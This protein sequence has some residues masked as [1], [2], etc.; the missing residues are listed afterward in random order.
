MIRPIV[1]TGTPVLHQKALEVTAFDDDLMELVEDMYETMDKAPGVGLA[2]P[3]VGV[4]LRV[5]VYNWEL[6]DGTHQRGVVIN[7]TL[8]LSEIPEGEPDWETEAEGC[9]SVPGERFPIRRAEKAVLTGLDLQQNP[10][11]IEA[12][13]WFARIFQHEFDHL[14]GILYVDRL[15]EPHRSDAQHAIQDNGWG[16]PGLSWLPGE[17]QLEG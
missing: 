9:L 15:A 2:A 4:N 13:G 5:F 8:E 12:E 1:I 3:Q 6:A 7:P 17:E 14:N 11:H 10:V 16:V